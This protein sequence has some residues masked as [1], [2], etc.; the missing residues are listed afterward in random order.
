MFQRYVAIGD[1]FTE[2]VGDDLPDG[3]VRGWADLVALGLAHHTSVRAGGDATRGGDDTTRVG[4]EVSGEAGPVTYANLAIRGKLLGPIVDQQLEPALALGPDLLSI[5]GGGNDLMRPRVE[6]SYVVG[7]LDRVVDRALE[8]GVHVLML[9]GANPSRHLPLGSLMQRRGDRLAEA[10]RGTFTR[11]GVTLVDNWS[12]VELSGIRYWSADK[13]HLNSRGHTRVA[14]NVLT[15]LGV[16]IPAAWVTNSPGATD[17][18]G[19]APTDERVQST[20]AYYRN[21]VLPWVGRRLTGRSSGD[22]RLPKRPALELVSV[23]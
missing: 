16:P 21:H 18:V 12:D 23:D 3:Q 6:M 8:Q 7:L 5:C 9:S 19:E 22:G 15:A 1:S 10:A 11:P 2:G 13:L 17:A 14:S 4:P 20:A